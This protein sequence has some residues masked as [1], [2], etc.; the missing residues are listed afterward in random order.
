MRAEFWYILLGLLLAGVAATGSRIKRLPVTTAMVYFLVG[1]VLGSQRL[2]LVKLDALADA[3]VLEHA[4]EAAVLVSLF[5]AGLKLRAPWHSGD[6]GLVLR[7][8]LG[9]MVVSVGLT[10][11]AAHLLLGLSLAP[12]LL[13]GAMLAPTDPVLAAQ[14][15]VSSPFHLDRFRFSLTGEAGMNDGS[16]F[17][18]LVLG[19]TLLGGDAPRGALARWLVLDAL[20]PLA[21]GVAFGGLTG[22][23]FGRYVL[24]LRQVHGEAL[25]YNDFLALG[26]MAVTY[27]AAQLLHANGFLAV[28][29]AGYA[30][31]VLEMRAQPE[32]E[33]SNIVLPVDEERRNAVAT[34]PEQ[35]PVYLT[36]TV[37]VFNEHYERVAEFGLVIVFGALAVLSLWSLPIA[38]FIAALFLVVRPAA[39]QPWLVGTRFRRRERVLIGW[40]GLRGI[41]SLYYLS[42]ALSHGLAGTDARLI[43][44][45]VLCTGTASIFI[46]GA[47]VQPLMKWCQR[48]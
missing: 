30:L 25:G 3:R 7:L 41:G 47:T 29:A 37:R 46:H 2:H 28:F 15:Q 36:E 24:H 8:A 17:P 38:A 21:A 26:L 43:A 11:V 12:A 5:T 23:L 13:L 35:G 9:A 22:T 45:A 27:G 33:A 4:S 32:R 18:F 19:L 31:R 1:L 42:Y 34:S 39:V 48:G 14:V 40:F 16:A 20:Y 6:W 10:A 44:A